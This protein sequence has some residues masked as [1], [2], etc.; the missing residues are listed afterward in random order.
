M[1]AKMKSNKGLG[2]TISYNLKEESQIIDTHNLVGTS[3]DDYKKQMELTQSLFDGRAKNLTAHIILSP[4]IADGQKLNEKD[5]RE[6]ANSF[7]QKTKLD[8]NE[9]IV[10]LHQDK[11]HKHL[12]IVAN[13]INDQGKIYRNG[14]ELHMSQRVGNE[15][16]AERGMKQAIEIMKERQQNLESVQPI[17]AVN[18]IRQDLT[19]AA[20]EVTKK[21]GRFERWSYFQ[22]IKKAGYEVKLFLNNLKQ[23]VT[24]LFNAQKKDMAKV[25]GY[26]VK[27]DNQY[28]SASKIGKEFTLKSLESNAL[29]RQKVIAEFQELTKKQYGSRQA[30]FNA[31]KKAGYETTIHKKDNGE[32]RGYSVQK[33]GSN[34]N[35]S[36]IGREYSLKQ[37]Q[38]SGVIKSENE[39]TKK[40]K[41]MN[42]QQV[43]EKIQQDPSALQS[44][45]QNL[46]DK[47]K[48][49]E[50]ERKAKEAK[51]KIA[52]ELQQVIQQKFRDQQAYFDA[53]RKAGYEVQLH[54]HKES[55]E[56][57]GYAVEKD[58]QSYNASE[59]GR[60]FS[61]KE[62]QNSG[63]IKEQ[64]KQKDHKQQNM[65][66]LDQDINY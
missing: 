38:K 1:I 36:D 35:A 14:S 30:Y 6:I 46:A 65:K 33:N 15:I 44:L 49:E 55:E 40:S 51:Q 17:G 31:L 37:L 18:K 3:V 42:K 59:V 53:L 60:E 54:K 5:W 62:L 41:Q 61:L 22:T 16:A 39:L 57:R 11:D 23:K 21:H 45:R 4:S 9:A 25:H 66:D 20:Q 32:V 2:A 47:Q 43:T 34:Y 56:V 7:L 24:D 13:R 28:Y 50:Q 12:H 29:D 10:F 27:K 8:K 52:T 26:G 63:V 48:Q 64:G 19:K 58:G